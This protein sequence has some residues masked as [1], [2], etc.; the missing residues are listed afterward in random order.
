MLKGVTRRV[1]EVKNPDGRHFERAVLYLKPESD[2]CEKD[3]ERA[4]KQY[5]DGIDPPEDGIPYRPPRAIFAALCLGLLITAAAL[6][7]VLILYTKM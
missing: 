7:A 1:V 6:A 3:A 4:A 5:L 2:L